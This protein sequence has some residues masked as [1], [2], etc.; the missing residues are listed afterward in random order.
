MSMESAQA[1]LRPFFKERGAEVECA[2]G[3]T[4]ETS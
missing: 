4:Q 3:K 1:A 2:C